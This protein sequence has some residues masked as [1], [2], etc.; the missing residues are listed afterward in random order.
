MEFI[1]KNWKGLLFC[2]A[3]AVPSAFL[4][5]KFPVIGCDI[6]KKYTQRIRER[7]NGIYKKELERFIILFGNCSAF[8]IF[9]EKISCYRRSGIC[10]F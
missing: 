3:I 10:N 9:R 4:G 7:E 6:I 1:K 8:C 5:K 2:L